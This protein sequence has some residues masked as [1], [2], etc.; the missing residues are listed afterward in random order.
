MASNSSFFEA[1]SSQGLW[2]IRTGRK[3]ETAT[4]VAAQS[5]NASEKDEQATAEA[6]T[7]DKTAPTSEPSK[8]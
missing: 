7:A 6:A 8:A 1:F 4:A 3:T 2:V 5:E